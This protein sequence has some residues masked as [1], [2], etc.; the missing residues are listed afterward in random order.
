MPAYTTNGT[1]STTTRGVP[2]GLPGGPRDPGGRDLEG[3]ALLPPTSLSVRKIYIQRDYSEGTGVK[4]STD[5]PSELEGL[6]DRESFNYL[7]STVNRYYKKAEAL[8]FKSFLESCCACLSAYLLYLFMDS[9]YERCVKKAAAFIHE[10]NETKWKR[11]GI[12]IMDPM[13]RGLRSIQILIFAD[14]TQVTSFT[15]PA[16]GLIQTVC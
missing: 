13:E 10:Q 6:M 14:K 5:F 8:S 16:T 4:F 3:Q 9:Y 1:T 7:I 11:R 2:I 12:L 15:D